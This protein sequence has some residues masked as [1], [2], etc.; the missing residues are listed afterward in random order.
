[1][2]LN[3]KAVKV[4]LFAL[5]V[6][7][8]TACGGGY[9]SNVSSSVS[10][11]MQS[12]ALSTGSQ[13]SISSQSSTGNQ[14]SI[15]SESE[16]SSET[17]SSTSSE[18]QH[19]LVLKG[20]VTDAVIS[21]ALVTVWVGDSQYN[22]T[23]NAQGEYEVT[24]LVDNLQLDDLVYI[25]AKGQG[26]QAQV[27][28]ASQLSSVRDLLTQA[29]DNQVLDSHENIS[30]NIT[31]FSTAQT[32]LLMRGREKLLDVNDYKMA[33]TNVPGYETLQLA[34]LLKIIIDNPSFN[35]PA[36]VE[37]TLA[38]ASN[39]EL[40]QQY[41]DEHRLNTGNL[42][43]D[44]IA[45]MSYD[46]NV[47]PEIDKPLAGTYWMGNPD[48]FSSKA[49]LF[50]FDDQGTGYVAAELGGTNMTWTRDKN[51][52]QIDIPSGLPTTLHDTIE[53]VPGAWAIKKIA[54]N[55]LADSAGSNTVGYRADLEFVGETQLD[56]VHTMSNFSFLNLTSTEESLIPGTETLV[57]QWQSSLNY[58]WLETYVFNQDGSGIL[59]TSQYKLELPFTW[60]IE[61]KAIHLTFADDEIN[62]RR[63]YLTV[64]LDVGYQ[65]LVEGEDGS[66][67]DGTF[68]KS[69]AVSLTETD[70]LGRLG[71]IGGRFE[72]TGD[73]FHTLFPNN[74]LVYNYTHS[75]QTW[76]LTG[77][78][79]FSFFD[80]GLSCLPDSCPLYNSS[81][82]QVIAQDP[83]RKILYSIYHYS[84]YS[85]GEAFWD[86]HLL[87]ALK[88]DLKVSR[89]GN[90]IASSAFVQQ[91]GD[92][93]IP[94]SFSDEYSNLL[95]INGKQ[96][97]YSILDGKVYL[98][99]TDRLITLISASN[100]QLK[101]C[102]AGVLETCT[103]AE[104][105][106]LTRV[107]A[108]D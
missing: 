18:E 48:N 42:I 14:S 102:L 38:F 20:V 96:E 25:E 55:L 44:A 57:G 60:S 1:M 72:T 28:L 56:Q 59:K 21:N 77:D 85:G 71:G 33:L 89:F 24:I 41:R 80:Y 82:I 108:V 23:A 91:S 4:S 39:T 22:V 52:I 10:S 105:I 63:I 30:L 78:N 7:V 70:L 15:S 73:S 31:N 34:A 68:I 86:M 26:V 36:D 19:Q 37:D 76:Q 8:L 93:S 2:E 90:W 53:G 13:E 65:V 104:L 64:N 95:T 3:S 99:E 79:S 46:H 100:N 94:W 81:D 35:L 87:L 107:D 61:D 27:H 32:V 66:A 49:M 88:Q 11:S 16:A 54:L 9:S 74:V 67:K 40:V 97:P 6:L 43:N 29:G 69:Q 58:G 83:V 17:A 51:L 62:E 92:E 75:V 106:K 98:P 12:S 103:E 5:C 47:L 45:A 84:L 101:V 50:R